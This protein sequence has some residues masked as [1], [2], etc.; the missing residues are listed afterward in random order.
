MNVIIKSLIISMIYLSSSALVLNAQEIQT[1]DNEEI[2]ENAEQMPRFPGCENVFSDEEKAACSQRK[3]LEYV[4]KNVKYPADARENEITGTV[5]TEFV[6]GKDGKM[7]DAKILREV[8][9]GC[10]EA[11]LK[12]FS[13][14]SEEIVW[15]PAI[16]KGVAVNLKYTLPVKFAL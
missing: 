14:M 9:G 8:G 11:V 4:Y 1:S 7:R 16:D 6:I 10:S 15:I 2:L 3:L 5:V 12:A 13:K